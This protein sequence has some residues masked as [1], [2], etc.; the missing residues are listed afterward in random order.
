VGVG[1]VLSLY[2][3]TTWAETYPDKVDPKN[4]Y[5]VLWKH[6]LNNNM[7]IDSALVAMSHDV[8]PGRQ[9]Q[10][11]TGEQLKNRF[12]YIRTLD[13]AT[14]YLRLCYSSP[15][16]AGQ[17]ETGGKKEDAVFLRDSPWMVVLKNEKAVD[18]ILCKGY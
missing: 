11:L 7:D 17:A 8:W 16:A 18:L 5:Y 2:V 9:V 6:G 15:G 12:G 14:P 13:E 4:S 10:A 1:V 3:L